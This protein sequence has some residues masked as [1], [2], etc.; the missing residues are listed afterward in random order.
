[1]VGVKMTD[2]PAFCRDCLA[3]ASADAPCPGCG[4]S[5]ILSHPELN[6]LTIAYADGR[7]AVILQGSG[8]W[9]DKLEDVLYDGQYLDERKTVPVQFG[10]TPEAVRRRT[11]RGACAGA[12]P[13][14]S[15]R[16]PRC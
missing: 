10:K 1:M 7:P 6:E 9:S 4:G 16:T 2:W 13:L 8:G 11:G 14:P 15:A 5:R 12:A 3:E